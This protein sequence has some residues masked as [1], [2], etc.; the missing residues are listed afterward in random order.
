[1]AESAEDFY[2]Q[3]VPGAS[4]GA[5]AGAPAPAPESAEDFYRRF[6]P[7]PSPVR[8]VLREE[9]RAIPES[10]WWQRV[11]Y[12]IASNAL[13]GGASTLVGLPA[14]GARALGLES[15]PTQQ[16]IYGWLGQRGLAGAAWA[17]PQ[18][19]PERYLSEGVRGAAAGL[20]FA[21][22]PGGPIAG[23]AAVAAGSG[24]AGALTEQA[25]RDL[26]APAPEAFG[27]IGGVLAGGALAAGL[28][29][30]EAGLGQ[31]NPRAR[32]LAEAGIPPSS[33]AMTSESGLT[34]RLLAPAMPREAVQADIGQALEG[35]AS[36]LAPAGSRTLR[37]GGEFAQ[38]RAMDW[39]NNVMPAKQAL[40]WTP[41]DSLVPATTP[42]PLTN[43]ISALESITSRGGKLAPLDKLLRPGLPERLKEAL[44]GG[45]PGEAEFLSTV[46]PPRPVGATKGV[47][48]PPLGPG[49]IPSGE[50]RAINAPGAVGPGPAT[51]QDASN[52]QATI[53]DALGN[54]RIINDIGE[55]NVNRLYAA[56]SQDRR[57]AVASLGTRRAAVGPNNPRGL[58]ALT[59]FDEANAE[60]IRLHKVAETLNSKVIRSATG[61]RE[62]IDPEKAAESLLASA[63]RGD[64]T[65]ARLR[66]ELPEVVDELAGLHLRLRGLDD[67]ANP[68]SPVAKGWPGA[69]KGLT[70]S[71]AHDTLFADPITQS[72]LDTLAKVSSQAFE[73]KPSGAIGKVV[74]HL[75][76]PLVGMEAGRAIGELAMQGLG[77][78][79]GATGAV[80]GAALPLGY[81]LLRDPISRSVLAARY[82]ATPRVGGTLARTGAGFSGSWAQSNP[83]LSVPEENP[84]N[85]NSP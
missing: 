50:L 57:D 38:A 45:G 77:P 14:A 27:T 56:L 46:R 4:A 28:R 42:V 72:K 68:A 10:A 34:R 16:D 1:M 23:R 37:Q 62:T 84:L 13:L 61:A 5:T 7:A 43:F 44:L 65:L 41:V 70:T 6:A 82:A 20:P 63:R 30:G 9:A 81:Y 11:P 51:W 29:T 3:F 78:I 25:A 32:E 18:S 40:A 15:P 2:R 12:Q 17:Q 55:A 47:I 54:P 85:P 24:A 33:A 75:G 26:G 49:Q 73:A 69:W 58:D 31:M 36:G 53:G 48:N 83:F 74:E 59:A 79:S 76:Y 60:S 80:A 52:L 35:I 71:G 19:G 39:V 22:L 64:T 21:L 8:Q 66:S 67:P